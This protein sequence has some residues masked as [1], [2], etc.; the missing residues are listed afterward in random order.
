MTPNRPYL[1]RAVHEWICDNELTPYL[2]V[3]VLYPGVEVPAGYSTGGQIILNLAPHAIQGLVAGN[4]EI[5]FSARFGGVPHNIVVPV[6]AVL[7][8]YAKENGEGLM[9]APEESPEPPPEKPKADKPS[10]RVVK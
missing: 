7:G 8:I 3:D 9:F 4:E 1:I 10:L 6:Q 5:L 2:L